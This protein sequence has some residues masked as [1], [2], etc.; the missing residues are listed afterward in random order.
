MNAAVLPAIAI[1]ETAACGVVDARTGLIPNRITYPAF[2][3]LLALAAFDG[4]LPAALL[5]ALCVAGALGLLY[6][7]TRGRGLGLGDV[8][9]GACMGA[10]L[11]AKLGLVAL[12][13]AFIAGGAVGVALLAS[14]RAARG[15]AM[16]FGPYLA[17]GTLA[18]VVGHARGWDPLG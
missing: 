4:A 15:D 18:A 14:R 2:A 12:G 17:L 16:R 10:A 3:L 6:G 9:L 8:K 11:G 13:S 1:L 5:G 7:G